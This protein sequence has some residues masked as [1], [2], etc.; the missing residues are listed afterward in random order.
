MIKWNTQF[1]VGDFAYFCPFDPN[2]EEHKRDYHTKLYD[3]GRIDCIYR[4]TER[5]DVRY[6]SGF[7]HPYMPPPRLPTVQ[8]EP[9]IRYRVLMRISAP[10][11]HEDIT[12]ELGDDYDLSDRR[13]LVLTDEYKV[14]KGS[15][16]EVRCCADS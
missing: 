15:Q 2:K 5:P 10:E 1:A 7:A 11:L 9:H 16:L 12:N 14:V 4:S 3:I 8:A 6:L 13:E